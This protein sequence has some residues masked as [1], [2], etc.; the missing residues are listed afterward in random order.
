MSTFLVLHTPV[1]SVSKYLAIQ[2]FA[3]KVSKI[4]HRGDAP[5][6]LR[7]RYFGSDVE[8]EVFVP[9]FGGLIEGVLPG[10]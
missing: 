5:V 10:L 6:P 1:T 9:V 2:R 8:V 7:P 3:G 4:V